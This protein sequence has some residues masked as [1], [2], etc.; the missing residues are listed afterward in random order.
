MVVSCT[1]KGCSTVFQ[2]KELLLRHIRTHTGEKPFRC[3]F[4]GCERTFARL[5]YR[6]RHHR[7]HTGEKPYVCTYAGCDKRF[8]RSCHRARHLRVHTD[9]RPYTCT[10]PKCIR[11]FRRHRGLRK[12]I[13]THTGERPYKC[14]HPGCTQSFRQYTNL[15]VHHKIH[16]G[17]RPYTCIECGHTFAR[18]DHLQ[19]HTERHETSRGYKFVCTFDSCAQT[20][21]GVIT[22][23][24]RFPHRLALDYHIQASHTEEGLRGRLH[25]EQRMA[26]F[27]DRE[28]I[29][30]DRDHQNLIRHNT[31]KT[32]QPF[33]NGHFSRPDFHLFQFQH[34]T[35]LVMLVG[36]DE[37]AHRRYACEADRMLKIAS[38]LDTCDEFRNIP[39]VYIRFNPHFYTVDGTYFDPP[40]EVRYMHL[41]RV[42]DAIR[43]GDLP[44]KNR[45][46][47]NVVYMYY[48][49]CS[50]HNQPTCL[51]VKSTDPN[52]EFV[53][54]IR[55]CIMYTVV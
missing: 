17:E 36:N 55:S 32:L 37:F 48:S 52:A 47:L 3:T 49:H 39:I 2:S 21:T 11:T 13:R 43:T 50:N 4:P 19:R 26:T 14:R 15:H 33:F 40:I 18:S 42:L 46:G 45:T 30:Y 23:N 9:E 54:V 1:F 41:L 53:M 6:V 25:S 27:F 7:L 31:C 5:V 35:N 16:T 44:L 24:K 51:Q 28:G 29:L 38:A 8:R 10:Y 12:H 20:R 22:C 34:T